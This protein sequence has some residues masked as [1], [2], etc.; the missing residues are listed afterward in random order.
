MLN[1]VAA[2]G[3]SGPATI[4]GLEAALAVP[5]CTVHLYGKAEA[6]PFRKMGHATFLASS[7]AAA[8]EAAQNLRTALRFGEPE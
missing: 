2:A 8:L 5:G 1:L 4:M 3:A 6:R 7:P